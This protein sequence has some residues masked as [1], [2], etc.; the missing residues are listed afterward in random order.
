M[1]RDA[2]VLCIA[3]VAGC[4]SAPLAFV[5]PHGAD[6]GLTTALIADGGR[7]LN[8]V[9]YP[10]AIVAK[11][12]FEGVARQYRDAGD[13]QSCEWV[14]TCA[15][16]GSWAG[17]GATVAGLAGAPPLGMIAAGLLLPA[18]LW[19]W[20]RESARTTCAMID[21]ESPIVTS[22]WENIGDR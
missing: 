15:R 10:G 19:S 20:T 11:V 4:A 22:A 17:F 9:G 18:G 21:E 13:P 16:S 2:L 1:V 8:P 14:A 7:E 3:L 12:F 5:V 6:A